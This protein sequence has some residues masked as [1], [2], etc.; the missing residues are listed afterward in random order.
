M[1]HFKMPVVDKK[2]ISSI[3]FMFTLYQLVKTWRKCRK[4]SGELK[5]R[6]VCF[7]ENDGVLL[8]QVTIK[9]EVLQVTSSVQWL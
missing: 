6:G 7:P 4:R 5:S 2:I 9:R 3:F 8:F 1:N